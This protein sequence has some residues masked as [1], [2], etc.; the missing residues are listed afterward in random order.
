MVVDAAYDFDTT[1][2]MLGNK[3]DT[4]IRF[5]TGKK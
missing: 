2:I 3:G 1:F 5:Y 4:V